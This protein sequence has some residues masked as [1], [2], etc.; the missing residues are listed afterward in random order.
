MVATLLYLP[1]SPFCRK[2]RLA[3][4]E[5]ALEFVLR[6]FQPWAD[7]E[8]RE[9]NPAVTVPV[10]LLDKDRTLIDSTAITEYFEETRPDPS[11]LPGDALARAEIRRLTAFYDETFHDEV[12]RRLLY[13]KVLKRM[14]RLGQPDMDQI[15]AGRSALRW[16]LSYL[17]QLVEARGWIAGDALS[18]ADLAAAA[19]LSCLDYLGDVPWADYPQ[20]AG[21]YAR[22]KSRPAF[23]P[24]LMDKVPGLPPAAHYADLDF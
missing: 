8:F 3:A 22:I 24:L 4:G 14:K 5:K 13:E 21:W 18:L 19:H 7:D 23:R 11:L 2:V 1:F 9:I 12:T 16:H 6:R 10:L 20:A 15:R 17:T